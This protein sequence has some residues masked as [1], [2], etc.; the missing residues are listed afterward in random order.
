MLKKR[1]ISVNPIAKPRMTNRDKWKK[2][3]CVRKYFNYKNF[4]KANLITIQNSS[5]H[6][7]FV[8]EMPRTWSMKQK[9]R[10]E[11]IPHQNRPDCDNLLKGFLD[12]VVKEDKLI[13]D[14]KI[15]KIWG[16]FGKIIIFSFSN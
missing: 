16:R 15:S 4:L 9:I 5:N 1:V 3:Q 14:I 8:I 7:I 10:M 6:I 11:G 2:R 13:W 12:S